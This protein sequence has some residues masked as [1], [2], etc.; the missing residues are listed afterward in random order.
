MGAATYEQRAKDAEALAA[1]SKFTS[2]KVA[3]QKLAQDYRELAR[4]QRILSQDAERGQN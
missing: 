1:S 2:H 4:Q 3:F